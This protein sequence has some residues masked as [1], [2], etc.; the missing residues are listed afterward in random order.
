MASTSLIKG[1]RP[2]PAGQGRGHLDTKPRLEDFYRVRPV[3]T[4]D[5]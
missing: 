4:L 5:Q 2:V 3:L 1:P